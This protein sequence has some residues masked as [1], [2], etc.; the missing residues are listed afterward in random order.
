MLEYLA[1]ENRTFARSDII[2]R[3]EQTGAYLG[4]SRAQYYL[5]FPDP[6]QRTRY[7]KCSRFNSDA[8]AIEAANLLL[9]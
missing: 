8:E 1:P 7:W 4:K 2:A 9:K 3:C 6:E 5:V